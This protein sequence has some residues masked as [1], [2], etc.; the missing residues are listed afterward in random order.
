M[1]DKTEPG[2][3]LNEA[4][5]PQ[6]RRACPRCGKDFRHWHVEDYDPIWRDGKVVCECG[7]FIRD[8]DAG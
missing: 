6:N 1:T 4:H 3:I 2:H 5:N 8:Y 7:Q